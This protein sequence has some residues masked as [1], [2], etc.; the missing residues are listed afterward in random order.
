L[1]GISLN[2]LKF[3]RELRGIYWSCVFL[4]YLFFVHYNIFEFDLTQRISRRAQLHDM[5]HRLCLRKIIIDVFNPIFS[6]SIFEFQM[7]ILNKML[8]YRRETELQG[9]L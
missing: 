6:V 1:T 5:A 8:T 7:S 4:V 2:N 3:W 9:A